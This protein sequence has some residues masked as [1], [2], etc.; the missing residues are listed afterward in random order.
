MAKRWIQK[1]TRR[2]KRKGTLGAFGKATSRKI[3]AGLKKGGLAAKRANFA[4]NM[5]KIASKRHHRRVTKR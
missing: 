3:K 2:M 1:A 4:R 5:K